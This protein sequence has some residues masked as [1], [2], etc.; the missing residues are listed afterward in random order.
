MKLSPQL[1]AIFCDDVRR[2]EGNKLS[3]MGVYTSVLGV[4]SFP[5]V[6][7]RLCFALTARIPADAIPTE[8]RFR[9]IKDEEVI[10]ENVVPP[11][12]LS[13]ARSA[14]VNDDQWVQFGT[15]FQIFPV[16]LEGP[17]F[18]RAR[19]ILDGVELK[20]GSLAIVEQKNMESALRPSG[21]NAPP[22]GA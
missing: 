8:L 3:Y 14:S 13:A 12:A 10:A 15:I 17:C 1:I 9:L 20:G 6:I 5:A 16:P 19:A 11:E 22:A 2:E 21:N 4:N 7:P 18:L